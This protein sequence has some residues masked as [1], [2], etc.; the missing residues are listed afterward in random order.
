ML[1]PNG[2]LAICIDYRELV[3]LMQLLDEI[4]GENNQ[5]VLVYAKNKEN[6]ET[7]LLPKSTEEFDVY[8]NPDEDPF[9]ELIYP[10]KEAMRQ[11]RDLKDGVFPAIVIKD[12]RNF[13]N[14]QQDPLMKISHE[15]AQKKLAEGN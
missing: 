8:K 10:G 4:F 14:P 1:K 2:I 9:G 3:R 15:K 5:Y 7:N 13:T 6:A 12:F 11:E